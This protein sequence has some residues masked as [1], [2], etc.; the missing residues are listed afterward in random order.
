MVEATKRPRL[1][2]MCA[3]NL[4]GALGSSGHCSVVNLG[5][6]IININMIKN[7]PMRNI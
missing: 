1:L 5:S 3:L 4:L 2:E 7:D 6:P